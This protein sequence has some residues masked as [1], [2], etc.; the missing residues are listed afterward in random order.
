MNDDL[1]EPEEG[2]SNWE[3]EEDQELFEHVRIIADT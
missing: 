3:P 1:I 2:D